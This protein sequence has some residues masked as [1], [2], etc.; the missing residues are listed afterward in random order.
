LIKVIYS[1]GKCTDWQPG[2]FPIKWLYF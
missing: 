1:V 2:A